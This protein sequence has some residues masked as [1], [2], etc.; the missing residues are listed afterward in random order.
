MRRLLLGKSQE[1]IAEALKISF[2]QLQK[3]E[4]GVNRVSSARLYQLSQLFD[5]SIEY[6][7]QDLRPAKK[8]AALAP[9]EPVGLS[10][11]MLLS[12]QNVN[13]VRTFSRIS[14]PKLRSHVVGLVEQMADKAKTS[15]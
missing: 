7:F 11:E 13:L 6:F 1:T 4:N 14:D 15:M 8:G 12:R 9:E 10:E 5:V 3:Y 2:Q